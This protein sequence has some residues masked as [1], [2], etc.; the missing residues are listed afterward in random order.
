MS[1]VASVNIVHVA[2]LSHWTPD[3]HL[4]VQYNG[5][6]GPYHMGSLTT[7]E[8]GSTYSL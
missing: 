8:E 5:Y 3:I 7:D 2:S 1:T 4:C 6:D